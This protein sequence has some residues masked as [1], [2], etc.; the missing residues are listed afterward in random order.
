MKKTINLSVLTFLAIITLGFK[1]DETPLEKLLKQ[2]ASLTAN[3]PTEKIHLHTDKPY[4]A[5]GE[6]IWLKA[7][8]VIAEKNEP[9]QL[10]KVLYTDLIDQNNQIRQS[11]TLEVKN[12][13]AFGNINII[14]SLPSGNYRLRAYTNYMR[15]YAAHFFFE[16]QIKI[17]NVMEPTA[18]APLEKDKKQ[19]IDLQFFPEGGNLVKGIRSKVGVKAV[20]ENGLGADLNG[21]I[22]NAQKEKVAVFTTTHAGMGVFALLPSTT[23]KH[24]AV[25]TLKDGNEKS[26]ALPNILDNGHVLAVN[27]AAENL[28]IRVS[29][30]ATLIGEKELLVIAQS[31]GVVCASFSIKPDQ[32][33]ITANIPKKNFPTG[34]AQIT[35]FTAD[36]KPIA[37]RLSFINHQD[38]LKMDVSLQDDA[39]IKKKSNIKLAVRDLGDNLVDG[40]FSVSVVDE[41]KVPIEEDE[42]TTI[43]SNILLTSELKGYIEK[44]NYYF[45]PA[46][47]D[48]E[49]NLDILLLTQGWR[50]F[51]WTDVLVAKEPQITF[52]PE[53]TLEITGK[54]TGQYNKPL[55][56]ATISLISTTPGLFLKIDT[57]SDSKGNFIFDRLDIPD[58]SSF[59]IQSKL[60]ENKDIKIWLTPAPNV[61]PYKEFGKSVN[62]DTYLESTKQ[63]FQELVKNNMLNGNGILLKTVEIQ[64]KKVLKPILNVPNSTNASGSADYVISSAMLKDAI[65]IF[66]PFYRSPGVMVR[67]GMIFR[68][69]ASNSFTNNPPMLLIVDGVQ[70]NQSL[71]PDYILSIN[72]ADVEGIEILTSNYNIAVLGSDASG[73]VIYIT[74]RNGSGKASA[75]TNIARIKNGG[76]SVAK[77]FYVPNYD[78]PKLNKQLLDLRST[79][80]WNPNV[81]T[82]T[83]GEANF[84]FFNASTPG[85]YRVTIEGMDTFG[86]IGRKVYTYQVKE[87]L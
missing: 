46:N 19:N 40:N 57:L 13:S 51:T 84:N 26:F 32:A 50:R 72:P 31:N 49:S 59:M 74:T 61:T 25:V 10:S 79:I 71:M 77:E 21:Y 11:L 23:E 62:I 29:S 28:A 85:N 44:P 60:K 8:L 53:Q 69:R 33:I 14:D 47:A 39:T 68:T 86:N 20:L 9:S 1:I 37:E 12:G 73:G 38:A 43:L 64:Q 18:S 42:E 30:S 63:Q 48:R 54:I 36:G 83:K 82:N 6:Q 70:I 56:K 81:I 55:P 45:N 16:K 3:Y 35:L 17:G 22:I 27:N 41:S 2:L 66:T 4:Y 34:I 78:D 65:N 75:A 24:T 52:R 15:N 67:N 80:Y 87:N 7:Y 5:V 76:F 58:S